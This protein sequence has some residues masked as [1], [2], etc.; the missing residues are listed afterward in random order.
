MEK[1]AFGAGCFWGIEASF[2]RVKGVIN[3]AVGYMG[4]KI[5]NPT[6]KQVCTDT[7]G[8]AEVV[9]VEYD[10]EIL[11]FEDLLDVFWSI[12]DPTQKNRQGPD[13]GSQYRTVIF[14]YTDAQKTA[15]ELSRKTL[16]KSGR[17][18]AS[19]VTE[20]HP[21]PEFWK[22]EEY[23]QRYLEKQGRDSCHI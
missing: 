7:T 13:F 22:A 19:I 6:Y 1:A 9:L 8:H 12:H 23:H 3:T 16:E 10:P 18:K 2:R 4:G 17:F 11:I 14:T 15:A 20:I 5:D 21:A